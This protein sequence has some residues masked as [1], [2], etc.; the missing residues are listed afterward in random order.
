M[1]CLAVWK[2]FADANAVVA[3]VLVVGSGGL[4]FESYNSS[5]KYL[6]KK[7][8]P[9]YAVVRAFTNIARRR[10]NVCIRR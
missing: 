4:R 3:V 9:T 10:K 7:K 1:S 8:Q 6:N 2:P 5:V